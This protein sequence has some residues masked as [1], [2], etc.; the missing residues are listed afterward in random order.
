MF[1]IS[2]IYPNGVRVGN[3]PNSKNSNVRKPN[4]HTWFPASCTEKDVANAANYVQSKIKNPK[5]NVEY[6]LLCSP[7]SWLLQSP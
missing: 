6:T 1:F 3:I 2:E 4:S 5:E 7:L